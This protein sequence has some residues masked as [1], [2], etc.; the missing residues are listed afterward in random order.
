MST[1]AKIAYQLFAFWFCGFAAA[2]HLTILVKVGPGGFHRAA[3][4]VL[5]LASFVISAIIGNGLFNQ[6]RRRRPENED[7]RAPEIV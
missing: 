2:A 3:V 1:N 4:I 6:F 5:M 7:V